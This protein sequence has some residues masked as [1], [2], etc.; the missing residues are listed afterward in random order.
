MKY[1][2]ILIIPFFLKAAC[3]PSFMG[4][5][6]S[7]CTNMDNLYLTGDTWCDSTNCQ[8]SSV[9]GEVLEPYLSARGAAYFYSDGKGSGNIAVT[10]YSECERNYQNK[11]VCR[12]K[13]TRYTVKVGSCPAG[14]QKNPD[15]YKCDPKSSCPEGQEFDTETQ[16]CKEPTPCQ[17]LPQTNRNDLAPENCNEDG[18]SQPAGLPYF[19]NNIEYDYCTDECAFNKAY[20]PTGK[21][22][23]SL[24]GGCVEP[25]APNDDYQGECP[26]YVYK[27][28]FDVVVD[29]EKKCFSKVI[30]QLPDGDRYTLREMEVSCGDKD[31][32]EDPNE[33]PKEDPKEDNSSST[34]TSE[35]NKQNPCDDLYDSLTL[36][37]IGY[38]I[39]Y[40]DCEHN[41]IQVTNNTMKCVTEE[42]YQNSQK[43]TPLDCE[44]RWHE[45]Y[46]PNTQ[47]CECE[48]GYNR[49]TFGDCWKSLLDS[50]ATQEQINEEIRQQEQLNKDLEEN[51]KIDGSLEDIE[52][53]LKNIENTTSGFR[54]DLAVTNT[55]L[56]DI[57][58][59]IQNQNADQNSSTPSDQNDPTDENS[60]TPSD[61]NGTDP[62]GWGEEELKNEIL[63]QWDQRYTIFSTDCGSPQFDPAVTFMGLTVE[64]PLPVM[65]EK[66]SPFLQQIRILVI[67]SATLL[68]VMSLFRR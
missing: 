15:T 29:N 28:N 17:P 35:D 31:P 53:I 42:D 63:N 66:I 9:K 44:A 20:C 13:N 49:N 14:T 19:Y 45:V 16:T 65:H 55:I 36:K 5:P 1:F 43:P 60:S 58:K 62:N 12:S 48:S 10:E 38:V 50:N 3:T 54:D 30:C 61:Q 18:I 46:N 8:Y 39:G 47:D 34:T 23:F 24:G 2:L 37:C 21:V 52:K 4:K 57:L 25:F 22:Y 64:N 68:G 67:L 33:D 59:E 11:M 40:G 7:K 51:G 41:G 32:N 6:F 27:A 56:T 26:G